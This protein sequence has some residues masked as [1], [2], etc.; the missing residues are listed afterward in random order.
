MQVDETFEEYKKQLVIATEYLRKYPDGIVLSS[1][2]I[3]KW[4]NEAYIV[5][6]GYK[7]DYKHFNAQH[8]LIYKAMARYSKLGYKKFNLGGVSN[9]LKKDN[10]FKGLNE[11]KM[12]FNANI[13][14]Y[15]GDFELITNGP[16]YFMY[17]KS[18]NFS[19][20]LKK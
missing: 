16:L 6:E 15:A 13:Y 14:E 10:K 12:N 11:F 3:I 2:L 1:A 8:L 4:Q 9:I 20:M 7:N 17:R 19:N 5:M 18:S